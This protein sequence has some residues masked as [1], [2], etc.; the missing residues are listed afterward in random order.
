MKS[1]EKDNKSKNT[2]D[3]S[4]ELIWHKQTEKILKDWSE[5]SSC[6]RYMHDIAYS[7]F[8]TKNLWFEF[9]IYI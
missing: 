6:Y 2:D 4:V 1:K 8:K 3:K 9:L 5:L 7:R